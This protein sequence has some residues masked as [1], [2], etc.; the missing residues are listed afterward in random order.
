ADELHQVT[1]FRHGRQFTFDA[2]ERV[3]DGEV[4]TEQPA[5]RLL[6]GGGG[7]LGDAI[8]FQTDLV[9]RANAG[10]IAVGKHVGRDVL[11]DFGAA[12]D[13][14]HG[15]DAAELVNQ[16]M[17]ADDGA[18]LDAHMP[19]E[20]GAGDGDVIPEARVMGDV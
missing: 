17:A 13:N 9:D 14:G 10:G 3:R 6:E 11:N 4:F 7:L 20:A 12:P 2:S 15:A 16:R 18:V 8:T 19:G 5:E 1:D